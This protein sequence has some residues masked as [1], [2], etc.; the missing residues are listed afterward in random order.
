MGERRV[1]FTDIMIG[2]GTI[3]NTALVIGGGFVG[4]FIKGGLKESMQNSLTK[5]C[6][7]ATVVMGMG[8][9][10]AK[11]FSVSAEGISTNG[12]MLLILSMVIGTF[13]G[14]LIDIEKAMDNLG[15]KIKKTVK[16]EKDTKFVEGFVN[17]SLIMC[18][19]AMAIVGSI[20]DGISGDYSM[21]LAKSILDMVIACVFASTYGV[22]V[23]FSA[24]VIFVYQGIITL[25]AF[26]GGSFVSEPVLNDLSFVGNALIMCVGI[27]LV[28]G[29]TIKVGNMLP[30]LLVPVFYEIIIKFI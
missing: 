29:K 12:S 23:L 24:L 22:G 10:L 27:N 25:I 15:E 5:A 13:F 19:G 4:L 6:G 1:R 16:A 9:A 18:V 3:I 20:Q 11:M 21:L 26:F 2:L 28:W 14:E 8:G 7:V 17:V 30:A